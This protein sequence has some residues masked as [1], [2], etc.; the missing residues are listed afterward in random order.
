[1]EVVYPS[2]ILTPRSSLV[3]SELLSSQLV[4]ISQVNNATVVL[5]TL[6]AICFLSRLKKKINQEKDKNTTIKRMRTRNEID[7]VDIIIII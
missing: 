2:S 1:M 6:I 5:R 3:R 7:F 4:I